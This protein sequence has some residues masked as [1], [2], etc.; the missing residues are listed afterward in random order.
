MRI[1]ISWSGNRSKFIAET[2]RWWLPNVIQCLEP[3]ISS[4][5]IQKGAR[6]S[7]VISENL[8]AASVGIICLT[9]ENQKAPWILF[10]AGA[11]SKIA[12]SHVCTFLYELEPS[13]VERPLGEF[14]HTKCEREDILALITTLNRLVKVGNPLT[15]ERLHETFEMWWPAF[16]AQ[17]KKIPSPDTPL[18]EPRTEESKTDE[19]LYLL[20]RLAEQAPRRAA[21]IPLLDTLLAKHFVLS[22]TARDLLL[23]LRDESLLP[24][25]TALTI[26]SPETLTS[27]LA[28]K[29][30]S[31]MPDID[32][33][34]LTLTN[35]GV[36][37]VNQIFPL[38]TTTTTV[39]PSVR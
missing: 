12:T 29:I 25:E 31:T 14:Q 8:E 38:S 35:K 24:L 6:G 17:L 10:E 4:Q 5:D 36:Q 28:N 20:R 2:L 15:S 11:L 33:E 7:T 22:E 39:D 37:M 19:M 16:D 3:F 26:V 30:V 9:P 13:D 34:W 27:M 1:F 32:G 23:R 18:P 21:A